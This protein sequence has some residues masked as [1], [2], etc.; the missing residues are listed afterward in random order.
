MAHPFVGDYVR[1]RASPAWRRRGG[2]EQCVVF[3][4]VVAKVACGSARL[5]PALLVLTTGALLLLEP[6]TLRARRRVPASGVLRLSLSPA[7]DDVLAVHVAPEPAPRGCVTRARCR[8]DLLLRSPH[9]IELATK[10]FL[11]AQHAGRAPHVT[12]AAHFPALLHR[13]AV[14]V[15]F[16]PPPAPLAGPPPPAAPRLVRCGSRLDVLL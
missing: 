16:H 3:A 1:L 9:A 10:L 12:L 4:D 2:L 13:R 8:G 6:K 7:A 14:D 5:S 15:C 11:V